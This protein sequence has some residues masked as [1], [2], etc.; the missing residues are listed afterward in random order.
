LVIAMLAKNFTDDFMDQAVVIAFWIY[1][2]MLLGRLRAT[3]G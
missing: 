1:V 3:A 2:G